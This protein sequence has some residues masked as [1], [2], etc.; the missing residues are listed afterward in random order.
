MAG[1][2]QEEGMITRNEGAIDRW[3]RGVLGV[4]MVASGWAIAPGG[5]AVQILGA[6]LLATALVGWCPLY[7]LLHLSTRRLGHR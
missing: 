6:V 4:L 2:S 7:T 1:S 5:W 3:L